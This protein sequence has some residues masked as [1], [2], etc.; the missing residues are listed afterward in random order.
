MLVV[1]PMVK[2]GLPARLHISLTKFMEFRQALAHKHPTLLMVGL[3]MDTLVAGQQD[4][5]IRLFSMVMEHLE[6]CL[7]A[8]ITNVDGVVVALVLVVPAQPVVLD[9]MDYLVVVVA[10]ERPLLSVVV[11]SVVVGLQV[12]LHT[13]HIV[14]ILVSHQQ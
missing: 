12:A 5:V 9:G 7:V 8:L 13:V 3:P 1:G 6:I 2:L 14:H 11:D 4:T 10:V